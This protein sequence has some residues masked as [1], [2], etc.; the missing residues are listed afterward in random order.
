MPRNS[1]LTFQATEQI[2]ANT[3]AASLQFVT[4]CGLN[5]QL[6][7]FPGRE[8]NANTQHRQMEKDVKRAEWTGKV[9]TLPQAKFYTLY[10]LHFIHI[11]K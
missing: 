4:K 5:V 10:T 11:I 9:K 3:Q 2:S 8:Q 6:Q 1:N 7:D